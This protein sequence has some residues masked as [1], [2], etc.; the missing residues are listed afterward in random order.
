[1]F[2]QLDKN[3]CLFRMELLALIGIYRKQNEA[4]INPLMQ[5]ILWLFNKL[6]YTQIPPFKLAKYVLS[7]RVR[8]YTPNTQAFHKNKKIISRLTLCAFF[9]ASRHICPLAFFTDWPKSPN[10]ILYTPYISRV[11]YFREFRE[12]GASR[13]FNNT[14]KYLPP[15]RT[16]ECDLCTQY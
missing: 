6:K 8:Y 13:E 14:R 5:K 10:T 16:H 15:I 4:V 3:S 7:I 2:D 12:S 9:F 11:F 1:M